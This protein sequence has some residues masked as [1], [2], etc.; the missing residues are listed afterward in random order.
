MDKGKKIQQIAEQMLEASL[1]DIKKNIKKAINS[2]A[3]DIDMW[4]GESSFLPKIVLVAALE[5]EASVHESAVPRLSGVVKQE[6]KNVRL[7]L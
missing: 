1:S 3:L 4:D 6:V 2:G 7:F 5:E